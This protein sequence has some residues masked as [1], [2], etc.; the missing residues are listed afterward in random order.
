VIIRRGGSAVQYRYPPPPPRWAPGRPKGPLAGVAYPHPLDGFV[1]RGS[2]WL[3]LRRQ[4][5]RR[6]GQPPVNLRGC[7]ELRTLTQSDGQSQMCRLRRAK[8]ERS[9]GSGVPREARLA[10]RCLPGCL[11][12]VPARWARGVGARMASSA[13]VCSPV[14]KSSVTS[15]RDSTLNEA[16]SRSPSRSASKHDHTPCS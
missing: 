14:R 16:S 9:C 3:V 6:T 12:G 4:S 10:V 1:R 5:W 11:P 13:T 15:S 8:S 7:V 2:A